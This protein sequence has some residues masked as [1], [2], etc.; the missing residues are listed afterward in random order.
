M[1][2]VCGI[3][4]ANQKFV[5]RLQPLYAVQVLPNNIMSFSMPCWKEFHKK[6][7]MSVYCLDQ[8]EAFSY[9]LEF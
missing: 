5:F 2:I 3:L 1:D 4:L 9:F 6:L 8:P 7:E